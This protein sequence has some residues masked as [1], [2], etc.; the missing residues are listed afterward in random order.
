MR[1][2]GWPRAWREYDIKQYNIVRNQKNQK[3]NQSW[4]W[5]WVALAA[6]ELGAG[7]GRHL[8]WVLRLSWGLHAEPQG[9]LIIGSKYKYKYKIHNINRQGSF[10]DLWKPVNTLKLGILGSHC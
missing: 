4:D 9:A 7:A 3:R 8:S 5:D 1:L 6:Q 2:G 10:F